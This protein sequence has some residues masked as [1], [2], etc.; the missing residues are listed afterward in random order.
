MARGEKRREFPRQEHFLGEKPPVHGPFE[1]EGP[2]EVESLVNVGQW[3][4]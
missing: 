2:A 1:Q 3:I 4:C